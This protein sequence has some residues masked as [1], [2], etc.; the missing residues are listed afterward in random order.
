MC[1]IQPTQKFYST[2]EKGFLPI[3]KDLHSGN[4]VF[5]SFDGQCF[6]D[7]PPFNLTYM[8]KLYLLLILCCGIFQLRAQQVTI[9]P[10]GITPAFASLFPK[11]SYEAIQALP[12]PQKGD[13][14]IDT[15]FRCVR[16]YNGT[17][18]TFLLNSPELSQPAVTAWRAVSGTE[19]DMGFKITTDATGNIYI[20][21]HFYGTATIGTT[22]LTSSG[23]NDIYVAKFNGI[24]TL[25]WVRKAGGASTDSG[26][27][28]TLDADG[29]VYTT[30]YFY[31]NTLFQSSNN[32]SFIVN[33]LG[34]GDGFIAKYSNSGTLQWVK[35]AG[36]SSG[37]TYGSSI[38]VGSDGYIYYT[39]AFLGSTRFGDY[40]YLYSSGSYDGFVAKYNYNG[41][42]QWARQ[43]GGTGS[44]YSW[45]LALDATDNVY[46]T[47]HITGT[48]NFGSTSIT[49]AGDKDIF[50]AKYNSGG[51]LQ[52]AQRAGG[53][54]ADDGKGIA[55][56]SSSGDIYVAGEFSGTAS[57]GTINVTSAGYSDVSIAK[58]NAD[59]AV[60]WV[61]KVGG[62]NIEITRHIAVNAGGDIYLSGAFGGSLTIGTKTMSAAGS[63]DVFVAKYNSSGVFQWAEQAG[64]LGAEYG[65][66]LTLSPDHYVYTIGYFQNSG[67]FG[68]TV[69]TSAGNYDVFIMKLPQ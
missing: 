40:T 17:K 63:Y 45:S 7:N 27:D 3:E 25:E 37:A 9:T 49:S 39:G 14:A 23:Y 5:A 4:T 29:N 21:G 36:N 57:F 43:I 50:I 66:G 10:S 41:G 31:G 47:G 52:W 33:S 53:T 48:A 42:L 15:T 18:W 1:V 35:Q 13:I 64:G 51:T 19:E 11:L 59:G 55:I 65:Y 67:N 20:I 69:L 12:S 22:S 26:T 24:G 44:D 2:P 54:G 46:I 8:R 68:T 60:Q 38:K 61:Q 62:T 32:S 30:G 28:I 16:F 56:N 6:S 34:S 58:Y